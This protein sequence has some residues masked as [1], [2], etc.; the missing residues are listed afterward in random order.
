MLSQM[1]GTIH[2]AVLAAGAAE[3]DLQ[4]RE[5]ALQEAFGLPVR[6][7]VPVIGLVSRLVSQKGVAEIFAPTYGSLYRMCT[8]MDMQFVMIGTGEKWCEDEIK[9]RKSVV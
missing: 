6:P 9:D 2:R 4:V 7:D 5:A 1:L 8:T 3:T